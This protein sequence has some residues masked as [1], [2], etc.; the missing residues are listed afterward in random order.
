MA[1]DINRY[2]HAA[3]VLAWRRVLV[4]GAI[5]ALIVVIVVIGNYAALRV[6]LAPHHAQ[7]MAR[8]ARVPPQPR[9]QPHPTADLAEFRA[10]KHKLLSSYAWTNASHTYARIPIQRAMRIYAQQHAAKPVPAST[11]GGTPR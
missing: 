5:L 10:A 2:G 7:V 8:R 9:L 6:W 11:Q 3:P 4:I 1:D